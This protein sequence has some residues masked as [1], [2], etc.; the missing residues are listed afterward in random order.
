MYV[1][2]DLEKREQLDVE[3]VEFYFTSY[4][5]N[6]FRYKSFGMTRTKKL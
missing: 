3:A 1:H 6:M 2:V 4:G 5:S